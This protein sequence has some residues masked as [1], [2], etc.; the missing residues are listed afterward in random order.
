VLAFPVRGAGALRRSYWIATGALRDGRKDRPEAMLTRYVWVVHGRG[1]VAFL[2]CGMIG[3]GYST[4][5]LADF[6]EPDDI[7]QRL[8][9]DAHDLLYELG[10]LPRWL[11]DWLFSAL[12]NR[13]GMGWIKRRVFY[14]SVRLGGKSGFG[15]L[16][17][18]NLD[19]IELYKGHGVE[20]MLATAAERRAF[21]QR[22]LNGMRAAHDL[23][24]VPEFHLLFAEESFGMDMRSFFHGDK[25]I[26]EALFWRMNGRH[27]IYKKQVDGCERII[28]LFS[29][30]QP[31]G[32]V[33]QLAYI[34]A[35]AFHETG[36]R[37]YAV[38]EG[39]R[40]TAASSSSYLEANYPS[41]RTKYWLPDRD[42]KSLARPWVCAADV[43]TQL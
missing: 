15:L 39:F 26:A 18:P 37:M 8:A 20:G 2:P 23:P 35:T 3:G 7:A 5:R 19:L 22:R 27:K 9:S 31:E 33:E 21:Q 32:T 30:L 29:G 38:Y 36:S 14:R 4:P 41:N 11:P 1:L 24:P 17:E 42:G 13:T 12:M 6:M 43:E 10:D 40:K 16:N 28:A 25:G 34:L